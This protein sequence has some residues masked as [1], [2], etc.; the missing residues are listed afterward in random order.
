MDDK[1]LKQANEINKNIQQISDFL[2]DM[3]EDRWGCYISQRYWPEDLKKLV[4]PILME[5]Q[6]KLFLQLKNL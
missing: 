1:L 3:D 4:R 5:Y 2:K 6:E